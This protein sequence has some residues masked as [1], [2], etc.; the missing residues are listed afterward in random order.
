M[1]FVSFAFDCGDYGGGGSEVGVHIVAAGIGGCFVALRIVE[2][3]GE[4][5][6]QLVGF[7]VSLCCLA[8]EEL[9]C[10]LEFG[11]VGPEAHGAS[12]DG[13]LEGVVDAFAKSAADVGDGCVAVDG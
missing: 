7:G 10:F 12:E 4:N 2:P 11:V 6:C 5:L 1:V 13:C 9:V 3:G 8:V